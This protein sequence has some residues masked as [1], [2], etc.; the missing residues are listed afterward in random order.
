MGECID[1]GKHVGSILSITRLDEAENGRSGA[2]E[3]VSRSGLYWRVTAAGGEVEER[4]G[5]GVEVAGVG[6]GIMILGVTAVAGSGEVTGMR[7]L[8]MVV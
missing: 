3:G 5:A 4:G 2:P 1:S 6:W 7:G 8:S